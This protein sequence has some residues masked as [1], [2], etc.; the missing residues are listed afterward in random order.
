MRPVVS[1]LSLSAHRLIGPCKR[2]FAAVPS[3]RRWS[4]GHSGRPD[5]DLSDF[6]R[7]SA[8]PPT[9]LQPVLCLTIT[10][11]GGY[12]LNEPFSLSVSP[13]VPRSE[14]KTGAKLW[15]LSW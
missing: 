4:S 2:L 5:P 9:R 12:P 8:L 6:H 3:R 7:I 10:E 11:A 13:P 1:G 15:S 14:R